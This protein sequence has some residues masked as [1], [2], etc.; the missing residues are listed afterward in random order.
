MIPLTAGREGHS[1]FRLADGK[2]VLVGGFN[3]HDAGRQRHF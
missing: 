1:A 2:V 3:F